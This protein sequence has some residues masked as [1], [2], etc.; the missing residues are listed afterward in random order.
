MAR[1]SRYSTTSYKTSNARPSK[2]HPYV[3][4]NTVRQAEAQP[5]HREERE[6]KQPAR[7]KRVSKQR[8]RNRKKA[9]HMNFGYVTFLAV[10]AIVGLLACIQF[11]QLR[12][13]VTQR[14]NH[15]T[16]MQRELSTLHEQNTTKYNAIMDSVNL[17]EIKLRAMDDLGMVYAEEGQ[18]IE[19]DNPSND[20]VKQH[21]AI[22]ESG[23]LAANEKVSE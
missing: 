4:G 20:Y 14:S 5:K 3:Q 15:I 7:Q 21:Q 19:Y 1:Q 11:L 16:A 9:M 13:E 17:E 23:V 10:A 18:I 8:M 2:E 22:P 12:A 6:V